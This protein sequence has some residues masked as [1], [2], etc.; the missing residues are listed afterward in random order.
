M[1]ESLEQHQAEIDLVRG[2]FEGRP[3]SAIIDELA[4]RSVKFQSENA[5]LRARVA[6]LDAQDVELPEV[7]AEAA[8]DT[9]DGWYELAYEAR[10]AQLLDAQRAIQAWR[11]VAKQQNVAICRLNRGEFVPMSLTGKAIAAYDALAGKEGV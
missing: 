4:A 9:L 2:W 6:I 10:C 7:P 1:S 8:D 3:D 5:K 11:G